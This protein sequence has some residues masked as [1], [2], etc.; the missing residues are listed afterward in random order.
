M[1]SFIEDI[2]KSLLSKQGEEVSLNSVLDKLAKNE[3]LYDVMQQI[4]NS[5]LANIL[6]SGAATQTSQCEQDPKKKCGGSDS[7]KPSFAPP[8]CSKSC[9]NSSNS[10]LTRADIREMETSYIYYY[11]IPGVQPQD[12]DLEV[13]DGQLS[14]KAEK[15]PYSI[16]SDSFIYKERLFGTYK[17]Q[18]TLPVNADVT[19]ITA[20]YE[21]GVLIVRVPK[22]T[23]HSLSKKRRI[24]VTFMKH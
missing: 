9:Q 20:K 18:L 3:D 8:S 11:D 19:D 17:T 21:H 1:D 6:N 23:P 5:P 12:I 22:M 14:L 16:G 7:H 2:A 4:K 10:V 15:T 24:P 13:H